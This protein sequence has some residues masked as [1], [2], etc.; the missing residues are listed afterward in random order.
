MSPSGDIEDKEN[1][2]LIPAESS[3]VRQNWEQ[4]RNTE[5]PTFA[6]PRRSIF[7]FEF[8]AGFP[9]PRSRARMC[10][11]KLG[12]KTLRQPAAIYSSHER[13][14][15]HAPGDADGLEYFRSRPH[16]KTP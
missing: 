1:K 10:V 8:P 13:I 15:E 3:R 2:A 6:G 14:G 16:P 12:A 5:Q 9:L 4:N 7:V 11:A